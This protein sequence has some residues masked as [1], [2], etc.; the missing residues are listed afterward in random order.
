MSQGCA[1][2]GNFNSGFV[3]IPTPVAAAANANTAAAKKG[4]KA[5]K[6][7]NNAAG[8][9]GKKAKKAASAAAAPAVGLAAV[10]VPGTPPSFTVD[11]Q[12]T[13][14]VAVYCA[15]QVHCQMGMV[16]MINPSN[17][18]NVSLLCRFTELKLI[19]L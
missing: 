15:Q 13:N 11:V 2:N 18:E 10:P 19:A 1:P 17:D 7:K 6:A 9:T 3:P 8:K 14:P 5:K 4:K 16:M 12:D